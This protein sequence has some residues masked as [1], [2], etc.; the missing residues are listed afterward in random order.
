MMHWHWINGNRIDDKVI[1]SGFWAGRGWLYLNEDGGHQQK[2]IHVE[3]YFGKHA[4]HT[5]MEMG[6]DFVMERQLNFNIG[7]WHLFCFYLSIAHPIFPSWTYKHGDRQIGLRVFDGALWIDLWRNDDG[8]NS[9]D[10]RTRPIVIHP[11]DILFGRDKHSERNLTVHEVN[12]SLPDGQYPAH[13]QMV[14]SEWRRPRWPFVKRIKRAHIDMKKPIP[15]PGKGENSWDLDDDAIFSMTCPANTVE[16]AISHVVE[17]AL[18]D[19]RRYG[20]SLD[21]KP[22][23]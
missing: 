12:V 5:S 3:W 4:R 1:G 20:G 19:R 9:K 15:V 16:E 14:L 8:W 2:T 21:W 13:I 6:T 17:S 18:R 11:M 10:W 22:E 7:L 23:A